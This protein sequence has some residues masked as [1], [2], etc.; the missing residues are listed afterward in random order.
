MGGVAAGLADGID[1]AARGTAEFGGAAGD[2]LEFL[3]GVLGDV[4]GDAGAAGV[5]VVVLLGAVVTIDEEGVTAGDAAEGDAAE[6]TIVGDAGGEEDEGVDAATVDG[7]V[8]DLF[9]VDDLAD[10]GFGRVDGGGVGGDFDGGGGLANGEGE[11]D[12]DDLSD[13][14]GEVFGFGATE[15]GF[16]DDDLIAGGG[17]EGSG[18]EDAG[19]VGGEFTV[20]AAFGV[21]EEDFG[22]G[23]AS[24]GGVGD[25]A[26]DAAQTGHRLGE[27]GG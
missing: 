11:L 20:D 9:G 5:F 17:D 23:Y 22:G 15:A 16:V 26:G 8:E 12:I 21:S 24:S 2:D 27:K 6:G 10:A 13:L 7:E 4:G 18:G 3:D 14:D 1:D 19:F 25:G